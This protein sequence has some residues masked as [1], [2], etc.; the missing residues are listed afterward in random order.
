[1]RWGEHKEGSKFC[2]TTLSGISSMQCSTTLSSAIKAAVF[3]SNLS[4]LGILLELH[5]R[6][7][8][9][10]VA[11]EALLFYHSI[12]KACS[13][14]L[15]V[16]LY[17]QKYY[18]NLRQL[19]IKFAVLSSLHSKSNNNTLL[20]SL[21]IQR[22]VCFLQLEFGKELHVRHLLNLV[23]IFSSQQTENPSMGGIF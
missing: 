18:C 14:T 22:T 7:D 20:R 19:R 3:S 2:L 11:Q 9:S 4:L 13:E 15:S 17:Q 23:H 1:M 16:L 6:T 5:C 12:P 21:K 8:S 10:V